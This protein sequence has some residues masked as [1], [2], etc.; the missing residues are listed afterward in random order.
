[1]TKN[2]QENSSQ[3]VFNN[4]A[5]PLLK[6]FEELGIKVVEVKPE[7]GQ[8]VTNVRGQNGRPLSLFIHEDYIG[9][10][11]ADGSKLVTSSLLGAS[12]WL[13]TQSPL[14]VNKAAK[15]VMKQAKQQG[16]IKPN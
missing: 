8:V 10:T 13:G 12:P 15:F 6:K 11:G 4:V 2:L 16:I 14:A 3:A 1:M 9:G 7:Y 5:A